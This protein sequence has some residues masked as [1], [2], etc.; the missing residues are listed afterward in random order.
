MEERRRERKAKQNLFEAEL[1]VL[2]TSQAF[3]ENENISLEDCKKQLVEINSNYE[4]LLDQ[5][6]L[7]TKVSDRLQKKITKAHDALE[8]TNIELQDT[9]DALTKAKVGR[10]AAVIVLIVF[11]LLFVLSEAFL[12]PLIENYARLHFQGEW[13]I[14]GFN[15][16]SKGFLALLFRPIEAIVEKILMK[17]AEKEQAKLHAEGVQ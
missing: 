2:K 16:G 7:I 4:D 14:Q 12:E 15:L 13:A 17:Q 6:K 9:L 10:K 3:L 5:S 11:I 1:Q 8:E